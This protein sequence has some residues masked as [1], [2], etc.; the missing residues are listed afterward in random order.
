[1]GKVVSRLEAEAETIL[2][3]AL[4]ELQ[5]EVRET[6]VPA[7]PKRAAAAYSQPSPKYTKL[8]KELSECTAKNGGGMLGD[9]GW[10]SEDRLHSFGPAFREVSKALQVGQWS[11][12]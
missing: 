1:M 5:Q 7:D 6:R 8:C 11:D 10:L 3:S 9:M 4:R 12:V 2:R